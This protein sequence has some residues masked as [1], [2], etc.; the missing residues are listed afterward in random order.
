M[1]STTCVM[2]MW[3]NGMKCRYMFCSPWKIAGAAGKSQFVAW[4]LLSV[5]SA[6]QVPHQRT[7]D[8]AHRDYNYGDKLWTIWVSCF[9]HGIIIPVYC[10]YVLIKCTGL[11]RVKMLQLLLLCSSTYNQIL[12]LENTSFYNSIQFWYC[13]RRIVQIILLLATIRPVILKCKDVTR[14]LIYV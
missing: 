6:G 12:Q 13:C 4:L 7:K 1:I 11:K 8:Q 14:P 3:R 5:S 2:S 9:E 10:I